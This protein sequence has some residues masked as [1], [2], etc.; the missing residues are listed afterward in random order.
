MWKGRTVAVLPT[1]REVVKAER[2]EPAVIELVD[3]F[4]LK[5]VAVCGGRKGGGGRRSGKRRR[6]E[7]RQHGVNARKACVERQRVEQERGDEEDEVGMKRE[8]AEG[9]RKTREGRRRK[10]TKTNCEP[11]RAE[12]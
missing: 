10:G 4:D 8:K 6:K 12:P 3:V 1:M 7:N 2:E 11:S 9:K 5:K